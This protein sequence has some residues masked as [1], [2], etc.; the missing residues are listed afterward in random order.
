MA[1]SC[2]YTVPGIDKPLSENEF[3]AHLLN[4]ALDSYVKEGIEIKGYTPTPIKE[5]SVGTKSEGSGVGGDVKDENGL[6]IGSEEWDKKI[7]LHKKITDVLKAN[8]FEVENESSNKSFSEYIK[9]PIR[10][11]KGN[12]DYRLK[13]RVSDHSLPRGGS[14]A[15]ADIRTDKNIQEA[16][17]IIRNSRTEFKNLKIPEQSQPTQ[18]G[19]GEQP[20]VS[21]TEET[22]KTE[23]P[24]VRV[25]AEEMEKAQP[26]KEGSEEPPVPPEPPKP[27]V[28]G[29]EEEEK[30]ERRRF[31]EQVLKDED[32]LP[33]VK[34]GV[35]ANIEYARQTNAMSVAQAQEIIKRISL[36]EAY[37]LVTQDN[38]MN[39]VVRVILGETLI[40][41]YNELAKKS[42]QKGDTE[43]ENYYTD[44]TIDIANYVSE[45]LGTE[46]G[47]M[48][49]AFSLY[50]RLSPGAQLRAA[51]KDIKEE[52]K[53]RKQKSRKNVSDIGEKFQKANEETADEITKSK[54]VK[55]KIE[56]AD[57]ERVKKAKDKIQKARKKREDIKNKYKKGK[58]GSLYSGVGL[59]KEG[60]EYVGNLVAT[61]IEEGV[62]NLEIIFDK[63]VSDLKEMTSKDPDDS[64]KDG[65]TSIVAQKLYNVQNDKISRGLRDVEKDINKTLKEL[66]FIPDEKISEWSDKLVED[67]KVPENE[68][69]QLRS[70][71]INEIQRIIEAKKEKPFKSEEERVKSALSELE[72]DINKI[73]KDHYSIPEASKTSLV[74]KFIE[75]AGLE[76]EEATKLANEIQEEFDRIATRK[77]QD[78]LYKEKQKLEKIK[79]NLDRRGDKTTRTLGDE[80]IKYSNLGAFD[81]EQFLDMMA[82]KLEVD[83]LTPKEA[84]DIQRLAERIAKAP[85]GSPKNAATQEL[86]AYRQNMKGISPLETLQAIWYAN[87]LS[88]PRTHLVNIVSTFFNGMAYFASEAARNPKSIPVLMYGAARGAKRGAYEAWHTVK[89]GES[90]IHVSKVETP[91]TLERQRFIG[92]WFN[93]YN[94]LKFVGRLMV[95][96]DVLQ[97][98][99]LKEMRATQLAYKEAAKNGYKDPF[100]KGTWR[101]INEKLLNTE[102]RSKDAIRQTQEE[103]LKPKSVEWKRRIYEIMEDS[104]PIEMTEDAYGFAAKGTFNH[105]PEGTLGALTDAISKNIDTWKVGEA[106][107]LRFVVP[108]T[109]IITNVVNNALDFGP[110]GLIRAARG[111]RGFGNAITEMTP[112]ERK[113]TIAKASL[114]IAMTAALQALTKV[115]CKD[116]HNVIEITGG[117]TG[118][119]KKDN[120][121]KESGWQPFSISVCGGSYISYKYTPLIFN[122]AGVGYW[123]D[124]EKYGK[125]SDKS[126][127][128]KIQMATYQTGQLALDGTW[129]K[130]TSDLMQTISESKPGQLTDGVKNLLSNMALQTAIPNLYNQSAQQI[131]EIYGLPKKEAHGF[132]ERLTQHIPIARNSLNDK[133]DYLGDP[134]PT[135]IDIFKSERK[136]DKVKDFLNEHQLW[137]APVNKNTVIVFDQNTNL[138]RPATEDEYYEF[139]KLRGQKI[140]DQV[141]DLID[142][143]V[144]IQTTG[145]RKEEKTASELTPI[146]LT[147]IMRKIKT[148]ATKS[149]KEEMLGEGVAAPKKEKVRI[150]LIEE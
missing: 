19:K 95:A 20:T 21:E 25:T 39:P 92:G 36:A 52:A 108:F 147:K 8:G 43:A 72:K 70:D 60:I 134:V 63:V 135:D 66:S 107:P 103:G 1:K 93:P 96:E 148:N 54:K 129:V 119:Y 144:T 6:N 85:E 34:K 61:Y 150:D 11:E 7:S 5:P 56:K 49:Q 62:Y 17:D 76:K 51:S 131:E 75:Q 99:A 138:E 137:V 104:R 53:R 18:E 64:V 46:G 132:Y 125:D 10:D 98:Q 45:K 140:K 13:I 12:V 111:K 44:K 58:G 40:K 120:Q 97:F 116:G 128:E 73:V 86:L 59:T 74:N 110:V 30:K 126:V 35:E 41:E 71:A 22:P 106:R 117:G 68:K 141:A 123:N 113:Q 57:S 143:G 115:P 83:K 146:E 102:Q 139:S 77:K 114:G 89:T 90:P 42:A 55:E 127:F 100:G 3:K 78:I 69:E 4:G 136:P 121:L 81:S 38:E 105:Q 15:N 9:V 94:Y 31:S 82:K 84:K 37:S 47:R 122:L 2:T 149:A 24:R 118:D 109:R 80:M 142:N 23:K 29:K 87:I 65:V 14:L 26:P 91:G 145:K 28:E 32:I 124:N 88:G 112:E 101:I 130:S 33:G 79:E 67:S 16:I 50:S 27:T 48:I 133:I